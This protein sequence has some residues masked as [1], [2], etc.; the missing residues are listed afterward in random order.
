MDWRHRVSGTSRPVPRRSGSARALSGCLALAIL[1]FEA[2]ACQRVE[3][4]AQQPRSRPQART[5]AR[6]P[7][8]S[9]AK[10]VTLEL[11]A[12]PEFSA[13]GADGRPV[14]GGFQVGYFAGSRLVRAIEIPRDS[15]RLVSGKIRLD[16]PLGAVTQPGDSSVALKVRSLS[17]GPLGAWSDSAGSVTLPV[18]ALPRRQRSGAAGAQRA[19]AKGADAKGA[20]RAPGDGR[21]PDAA[22]AERG[23]RRQARQL[24]VA[25]LQGHDELKTLVTESLGDGMT[26]EQAVGSFGKLQDLATAAL[27]AQKLKLPFAKLCQAVAATPR[28]SLVDG[29]KA[30]QP[31][32]DASA[33][34][35]A[36][37][38]SARKL[39]GRQRTPRARDPQAK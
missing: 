33:E 8:S 13:K 14:I 6:I 11:D 7:P 34:I 21:K 16:V 17:S 24:G 18:E 12:P 29:L 1:V 5:A 2:A 30:V 23:K 3:S 10:T 36:V 9:A 32:I 38:Q 15:V 22:A 31:S 4:A 35:K 39:I 37:A 25:E 26:L 27:V 19:D 20:D 28:R